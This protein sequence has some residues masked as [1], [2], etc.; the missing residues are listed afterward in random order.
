MRSQSP[1]EG[2]QSE[3]SRRRSA[4][5]AAAL[6][7][8][9]IVAQL[10]ATLRLRLALP[11]VGRYQSDSGDV[12]A[13]ADRADRKSDDSASTIA[14]LGC[15]PTPIAPLAGTSSHSRI[16]IDTNRDNWQVSTLLGAKMNCKHSGQSICERAHGA[17]VFTL[18]RQLY[19]TERAHAEKSATGTWRSPVRRMM[20]PAA[21]V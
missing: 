17:A 8:R 6:R 13:I 3:E 10:G 4:F 19:R 14:P 16:A 2:Y 7:K 5:A 20:M 1:A 12:C 11:R 18:G 15:F 21:V 9:T